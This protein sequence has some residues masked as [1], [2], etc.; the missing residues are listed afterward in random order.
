MVSFKKLAC[1]ALASLVM[2]EDAV[3]IY[4]KDELTYT[5]CVQILKKTAL[6]FKATSKIGYCNVKTQQALGS[7]AY[8]LKMMPHE[9]G[10]DYFIDLCSAYNLTYLDVEDAYNNA[11]DYLVTNTTAYPGFELTKLFYLPVKITQKKINGAYDSVLGRYYNFNRANFYGWALLLYWYLLILI[12]ALLQ[13]IQ[14]V[15][16]RFVQKFNGKISNTY[17]KYVTMAPL[18]RTKLDT[19]GTVFKVFDFIIPSRLETIY[20]TIWCLMALAMNVSNFHHDAP[21]VYWKVEYAE[22]GRKIAD[23]SGVMVLYLIPQLV[24]FA[25]RNNFLQWVSG[26]SFARFNIFHRWIARLSFL[27]MIVHGIAIT[28]NGIGSANYTD[29]NSR[30]YVRCGYAAILSA[31]LMCVHSLHVVRKNNYEMFVLAHNILGILF[32]ACTWYHVEVAGGYQAFLI[33]TTAVW[34]FDKVV[35]FLRLAWFGVRTARVQLIADETLRV[36]VPR[37]AH[38]KPQ[39]LSHAFI[40]FWRRSC[41]WQ[42]HPFTIVDS[43][44][45]ENTVTFYIKVKGGMSNKLYQYLSSQP[46][47]TGHIKCSLEGP[48]GNR[49]ALQHYS[50]VSYLSGGNGI[51][52]LFASA[53]HLAVRNT[54]QSLK[55]YWIIRHWKSIEWFYEELRSLEGTCVKPVIYVTQFNTPLDRCFIEKFESDTESSTEKESDKDSEGE[56]VN[57]HAMRLMKKLHFVEFR[58][59]R[60]NLEEIVREDIAE[61]KGAVA[62]VGCGHNQF[63]DETRKIVRHNMPEGKR[64][65]FHDTMG[66]W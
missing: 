65:D 23:R 47:Q 4:T 57:E 10:L 25:G 34:G 59:G 24:L 63:V 11:T 60:P 18:G 5:A 43:A 35:R 3:K 13:L 44:V 17:R 37:P 38:W 26:W 32:V 7:M 66:M 6:F 2:A 64:V 22:I 27:L 40:Y 50:S 28:F 16:P 62:F 58:L 49:H 51:P 39:P 31:G 20:I 41:F 46:D 42:S 21:N 52:G 15:A 1:L 48:Y 12:A 54:G 30:A 19:R 61:S 36:S 55:L 9:G 53:K 56:K 33:A 29:R 8:C 14:A 45:E